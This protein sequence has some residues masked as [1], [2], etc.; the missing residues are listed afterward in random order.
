M[1]PAVFLDRPLKLR[2][3]LKQARWGGR[4]LGEVLGRPIGPESDWAESWEV[5]DCPGAKSVIAAGPHEG[6]TL[7]DL[8]RKFPRQLLGE[9]LA[10]AETPSAFPLLIK[11]LDA[12]DVLSVQ[13]HP[14]DAQA[15]RMDPGQRGKTEAW[16]ILDARPDSRLYC[17]LKSGID[18]E[19]LR[20]AIDS[21]TVADCLH[22]VPARRG[23][24]LFIPAGTV[25]AIGGGIL[26]AEV[27][28]SSDLTFRLDDWGRLGADGQPRPLHIGQSLECID[29]ARGPVNPVVPEP[30][31]AGAPPVETLVE[32]Q[33]FTIRRHVFTQPAQ[34]PAA[35]SCRILLAIEGQGTLKFGTET[36]P[37]ERAAVRLIPAACGELQVV[38]ADG[39]TG[40]LTVLE[41]GIPPAD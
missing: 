17:G 15:A 39:S 28:Q 37:L 31:A 34:L 10:R 9:E 6:E 33:Y 4:Q 14:N 40:G 5:A 38:P 1:P 3:I 36:D 27:Q 32:C 29:F 26:L 19:Q 24:C 12:A 11:Y 25:H 16:V 20:E 30:A 23:D 13:V 22:E 21:G 18:R 2:P 8:L 35:A 7:A 41:V